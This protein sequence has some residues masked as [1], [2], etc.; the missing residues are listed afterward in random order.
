MKKTKISFLSV[1]SC[2]SG[3]FPATT[4]EQETVIELV[5]VAGTMIYRKE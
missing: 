3:I 4:G 2:R 5:T 1:V